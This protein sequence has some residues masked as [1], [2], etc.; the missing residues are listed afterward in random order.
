MGFSRFAFA[1][2]C[3][4]IGLSAGGGF[5]HANYP[6]RPIRV[7]LGFPA[8]SGAD[9]LC[10]WFTA[11][12]GEAGGVTF[13]VD[14][15][16]GAAGN[17]S[18]EQVAK[19]KPDGYT[20]LFGGAAGIAASPY[21]YKNLPFDA[22][23]D[24]QPVASVAE[25]VF[26]LSVS[27]N[28]P[29]QSVADLSAL[30][31]SKGPK[32]TYGW[33]VTSSLASAVL[34]LKDVGL[35]DVVQV[36]YK[37]TPAATSDAAAGQVD[38]TFADAMYALGQEKAGKVRL[39]A[40]TG[41]RRPSAVPDRPTMIEAGAPSVLVAPWWAVFTPTGT[42]DAVVAQLEKWFSA[43]VAL[44]APREFLLSQ[45]ADAL[46]GDAAFVRKRLEEDSVRWKEVTTLAK[47]EPL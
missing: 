17:L 40:T 2:L 16:P 30:L 25:L 11:K 33:A 23:K 22:S 10:R 42:P 38:F 37:T 29:V 28:S 1:A 12:A 31:K 36:T 9:I 26:A 44:P 7:V 21:I 6:E 45:G 8:G 43:A 35:K 27:T 46:P 4:V 39:L 14:N 34:Y 15:K 32:A 5:A 24:L 47:F 3:G 41:S 13:I 20:I 19:A 18:V